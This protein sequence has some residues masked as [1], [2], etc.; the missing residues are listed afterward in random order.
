MFPPCHRYSFPLQ[1]GY[2]LLAGLS[3]VHCLGAR[4]VGGKIP[5]S[6]DPDI[7][8]FAKGKLEALYEA[9]YD[10]L[11][12]GSVEVIGST[13]QV[14]AGIKHDIYFLVTLED[15]K[16]EICEVDVWVRSWLEEDE[17]TQLGQPIKCGVPDE[18]VAELEREAN[19]RSN[20]LLYAKSIEKPTLT[21]E[22][23]NIMIRNLVLYE[24]ECNRYAQDLS[25]CKG[26]PNK[27][28]LSSLMWTSMPC[29]AFLS[30][31]RGFRLSL[32]WCRHL[33][34]VVQGLDRERKS[35]EWTM[36]E[37]CFSGQIAR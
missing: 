33:G 26:N 15:D 1:P 4:R 37:Y 10:P 3:S 8:D 23:E 34:Q 27:P 20:N 18:V 32:F 25:S 24:T 9:T 28:A 36:E 22:G 11:L 2:S 29:L 13:T 6:P 16:L 30:L 19:D 17:A 31:V 21:K 7:M 12:P 14:V 5:S 35:T